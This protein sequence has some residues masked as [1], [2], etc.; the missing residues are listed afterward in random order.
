[1]FEWE[2]KVFQYIDNNERIYEKLKKYVN[3][4]IE[5]NKEFNLTG[6]DEEKIWCDGIYQSIVILNNFID[7]NQCNINLLDIGA[8]AGF[9]SIPFY[10]FS[11][12]K[13]NLTIYEPIKKRVDFLNL[14][15]KELNLK[16]LLI[17]NKRIEDSNENEKFNFICARA[18]MSLNML[19]EVSSKCGEINC[20][21]VFLKSKNVYEELENSK[22]II[23]KL[24][25]D[26]LKIE[27]I[28][29]NDG[30]E[31][32]IV[33]YTKKIKTPNGIPRKWI[34]IKRLNK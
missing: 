34:E 22:N 17:I 30:K 15:K 12:D 32:N 16:N 5:K 29:L 20:N 4:I 31:H 1:M 33:T 25:I 8:G 9:P 11:Q 13:I 10:I 24:S 27:K 18:V 28:N 26:D 6:F 7:L 2:N 21:Y 3:L 19:I 14:V 23:N